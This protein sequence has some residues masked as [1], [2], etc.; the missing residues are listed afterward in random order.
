MNSRAFA[1]LTDDELER[2]VMEEFSKAESE[3]CHIARDC[4]VFLARRVAARCRHL[5]QVE[6]AN[7]IGELAQ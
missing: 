6:V 7:L 2:I 3:G 1:C 4:E 5:A